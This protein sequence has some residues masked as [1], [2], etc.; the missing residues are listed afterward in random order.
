MGNRLP[1]VVVCCLSVLFASAAHAQEHWGS[2][3]SDSCTGMGT[4][5]F[6]AIL[7]GIPWGTSWEAEC[8]K[9]P[10][11]INGHHFNAPSRCKNK[12]TNM[13]GEFDVPDAS[14]SPK[15]GTFKQDQC[16]SIG[17]RQFSSILRNIPPNTK[18]EAACAQMPAD[19]KGHHF[20]APA[21]CVTTTNEWGQFDVPDASC[22]HWGA[23][24]KDACSLVGKRQFSAILNDV[25]AGM[26]WET[27][28][29]STGATIQGKAFS[30][31]ARC[32][33]QGT[34][35]WGEFDVADASCTA[36]A[37]SSHS[38]TRHCPPLQ[39]CVYPMPRYL[40]VY[41]DAPGQWDKDVAAARLPETRSS[42]DGY[43]KALTASS[44]FA[45]VAQYGVGQPSFASSVEA[46]ADC[47]KKFPV[48]QTADFAHISGFVACEVNSLNLPSTGN[49]IVNLFLPPQVT[50]QWVNATVLGHTIKW[51]G[52][53]TYAGYHS[54][55]P[56][57]LIGRN[58]SVAPTVPFAVLPTATSCNR[59]FSGLTDTISHEMVEAASNPGMFGWYDSSPN[60]ILAT[61][62]P[63]VEIGDMCEK[64][65]IFPTSSKKF[66]TGEVSPYWSNT[67]PG[68]VFGKLP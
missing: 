45:G 14:C 12:T 60:D 22:P 61:G 1:A 52:C 30:S 6:S 32:S 53:D 37:A 40:N 23:F 31:P 62:L 10:A 34:A 7:L 39:T 67:P 38:V 16:T 58:L 29:K 57:T 2:F 21:R 13:W 66:S 33:N 19:I 28:C 26:S 50:P 47:L 4:R 24:K 41:W 64:G 20:N 43:V 3:Q 36:P 17:K 15:W 35:M 63:A 68:C 46:N 44:Y 18:W 56:L 51:A 65:G 27:V 5:Q 9:M 48:P 49:L 54:L 25:P 59:D 42:I 11:D 55:V 8:A